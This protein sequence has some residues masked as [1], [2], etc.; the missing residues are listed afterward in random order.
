MGIEDIQAIGVTCGET[1]I[2]LINH[3]FELDDFEGQDNFK[4]SDVKNKG[5]LVIDK[6][7]TYW[8]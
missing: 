6:Y 8:F 7:L 4:I 3:F 1:L 2:E 5:S